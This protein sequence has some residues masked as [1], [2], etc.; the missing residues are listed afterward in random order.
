MAVFRVYVFGKAAGPWQSI[1]RGAGLLHYVRKDGASRHTGVGRYLDSDLRQNDRDFRQN[2]CY[3]SQGLL[4]LG[5][6]LGV[7]G[8]AIAGAGAASSSAAAA[9]SNAIWASARSFSSRSA[10]S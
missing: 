6:T 1:D 3:L 4:L 8:S 9:I 7:S 2:D 10:L 5:A